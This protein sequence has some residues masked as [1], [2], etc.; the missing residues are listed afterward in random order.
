ML[1]KNDLSKMRK[2]QKNETLELTFFL[3]KNFFGDYDFQNIFV[4]CCL[5]IKIYV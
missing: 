5:E 4:Y 3:S 1:L 2:K